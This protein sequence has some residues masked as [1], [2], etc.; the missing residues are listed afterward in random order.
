MCV[1]F[2]KSPLANAKA[3]VEHI[4]TG[5]L[6]TE[7]AEAMFECDPDVSSHR[8]SCQTNIMQDENIGDKVH[9]HWSVIFR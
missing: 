7:L 6:D 8:R 3:K 2:I 5:P 1:Q 9:R 4:Y